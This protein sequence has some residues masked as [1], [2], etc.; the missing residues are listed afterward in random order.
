MHLKRI[1][2]LVFLLFPFCKNIIE[3]QCESTCHFAEQCAIEAQNVTNFD[4]KSLEKLHIE[5]V[6]GCTMFQQEFL[7]CKEQSS[8]SCQ[9]FYE[10]IF[11][12]GVFQ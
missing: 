7:S 3:Q 4:S 10:C 5:C 8:N 6:S 12:S 9:A 1:I 11:S 2:V